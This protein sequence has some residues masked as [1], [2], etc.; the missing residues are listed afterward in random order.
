MELCRRCTAIVPSPDRC[1]F[2]ESA[3][4]Q[5]CWEQFGVCG[6]PGSDAAQAE[7]KAARTDSE[8]STILAKAATRVVKPSH[9]LMN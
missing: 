3:L 7:L 4:C 8:R 5:A 6:C 2:C 1:W 9:R